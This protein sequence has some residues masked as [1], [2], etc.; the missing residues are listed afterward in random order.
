[1]SAALLISL[2]GI[3]FALVSLAACHLGLIVLRDETIDRRAEQRKARSGVVTF[4]LTDI[5]GSSRLWEIRADAM[6]AAIE[7]HDE[8]VSSSVDRNDGVVLTTHGEGDSIFAV[9]PL[10]T[11]AVT[12]AYEIQRTLGRRLWPAGIDLRVRIALH[13]GEAKGDYRGAAAN[14]CARVRG[15]ARGGEVLL[16]AATVEMVQDELPA[17]G[18]LRFRGEYRLRDLERPEHVFQLLCPGRP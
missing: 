9:F 16:T 10:A 5:E 15:L 17:G 18:C 8:I 7:M 1:M 3:L 2:T 14:R 6:R 4:L 13:T 12:A 11:Q